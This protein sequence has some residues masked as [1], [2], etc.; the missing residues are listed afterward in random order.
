MFRDRTKL[1]FHLT[2]K[3]RKKYNSIPHFLVDPSSRQLQKIIFYIKGP[4]LSL[5]KEIK[6]KRNIK[7]LKVKIPIFFFFSC[8]YQKIFSLVIKRVFQILKYL[9]FGLQKNDQN[10]NFWRRKEKLLIFY[11]CL[12]VMASVNPLNLVSYSEPDLID[13][14]SDFSNIDWK[15]KLE[16]I[17]LPSNEFSKTLKFLLKCLRSMKPIIDDPK[18][19]LS[20]ACAVEVNIEN[21]N[22][23]HLQIYPTDDTNVFNWCV[24]TKDFDKEL[25]SG[26]STFQEILNSNKSGKQ[27]Q[28]IN[29]P[30][31]LFWY[32]F[33]N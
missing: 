23:T 4:F 32:K 22:G 15:K 18:L 31:F 29:C 7:E 3:K 14:P 33:T 1:L 24:W 9:I 2:K 28:L 27:L 5:W 21:E 10:K 12:S 13:F 26:T 11:L 16:P 30:E 25:F 17:V 8:K 20:K 19:P 6:Q